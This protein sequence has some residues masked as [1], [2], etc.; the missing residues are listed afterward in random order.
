[1]STMTRRTATKF[2]GGA[3]A[4]VLSGLVVAAP[5]AAGAVATTPGSS[6]AKHGVIVRRTVTCLS[7]R[8]N[9]RSAPALGSASRIVG[10][11]GNGT[12]L[13][14]SYDSTGLWFKIASGG[15]VG[16]WVTAAVLVAAPARTVNGRLNRADLTVL[17]SWTINR[18][19]Q[20]TVLRSL[21]RHAAIAYLSMN[22]EF[23]RR[24]GRNL[25]ITE[26]YR[27][28]ARQ[29]ELYRLL[30]SPTA[31]YPGTSN[32]GM[33]N[34]IDFGIAGTNA[35]TS[36]LFYGRAYD[37]W[38][39]QNAARWGFD[40]PSYMDRGGSNQEWWHYNFVG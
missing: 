2:C 36:L 29:Q 33:G 24:F 9:V 14:G 34:A 27:P 21:S 10:T 25:T 40:R 19:N 4:S 16:S 8:V 28:L 11:L 18:S 15:R 26:A 22:V 39:S 32:H 38:L 1:M 7:Y 35:S 17:P 5:N 3:A 13:T 12:V 30:G 6:V 37:V 31:A 20:P 23:R